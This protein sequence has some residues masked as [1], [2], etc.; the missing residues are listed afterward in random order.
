MQKLCQ[1][2]CSCP[3]PAVSP[4]QLWGCSWLC[5]W[6]TGGWEDR[7]E[8]S[9]VGNYSSMQAQMEDISRLSSPSKFENLIVM[10]SL[11]VNE[12][13]LQSGFCPL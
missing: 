2:S 5:R 10:N 9:L 8:E 3:C 6:E 12:R 7:V 4:A 13:E 1:V 11:K